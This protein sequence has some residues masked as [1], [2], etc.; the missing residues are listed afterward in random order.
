MQ[1]TDDLIGQCNKLIGDGV[2]FP[3]IWN[4][5]LRG[6][7]LVLGPPVQGYRNEEP[8]LCIPLFHRQTLIFAAPDAKFIIE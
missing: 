6:H 4:S 7:Q 2:D 1:R 5:Y 3:V 8:V